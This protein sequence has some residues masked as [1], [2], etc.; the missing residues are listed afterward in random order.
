VLVGVVVSCSSLELA[1]TSSAAMRSSPLSKVTCAYF[2][3]E[4][5]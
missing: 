3:I 5:P 2:A 4:S 1:V